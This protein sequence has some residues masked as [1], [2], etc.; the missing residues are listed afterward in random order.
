MLG[1]YPELSF[2]KNSYA[3]GKSLDMGVVDGRNFELLDNIGLDIHGVEIT[4][5]ILSTFFPYFKNIYVRDLYEEYF[6]YE[7][8]GLVMLATKK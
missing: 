4:E 1:K 2:D 7:L 6:G 5:E 3:G 8:S